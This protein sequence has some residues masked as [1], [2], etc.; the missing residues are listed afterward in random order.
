MQ[1]PTNWKEYELIDSG[2][3]SKLERWG[4]FI[5]S[6]P[7]PQ[8]IWPKDL[9]EKDWQKA[10]G[11]YTR[12]SEGVGAW[13]F[14][15]PLPEKWE[16]KYGDLKFWVKPTPFKHT[17]LFPEQAIN[18]DWL[19][20]KIAD[21]K[22]ELNILN[23][24]GYTGGATVACAKAG[25]KICH[26]DASKGIVAWAKENLELSGLEK[27][28]VR[29]IIDDA[30][31]FVDKEIRRGIKYDGIIMDPPSFGRG[32]KGEVWKIEEN[33]FNLVSKCAQTLSDNPVFFM[34][35]SYTTG[36]S[37]TVSGNILKSVMRKNGGKV[38]TD[39]IGLVEKS[40]DKIL[41]TGSFSRWS[42]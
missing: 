38:E 12:S 8:A 30:I 3:G 36:L 34:I 29:L 22:R 10:D 13:K 26:V 2:D 18:W 14:K 35:N 24:F 37:P 25:A 5:L 7:D 11:V 32:A 17:G 40:S 1:T 31:K 19:M 9:T 23:L 16:I 6:R 15:K 42:K 27:A 4:N 28:P 41:P 21:E 20:K 33:L 39:E